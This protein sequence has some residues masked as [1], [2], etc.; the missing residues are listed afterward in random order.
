ME[1]PEVYA[2]LAEVGR[3]DDDKLEVQRWWDHNTSE[4]FRV[5][6]RTDPPAVV[7]EG[8]DW[9]GRWNVREYHPGR[10]TEYLAGVVLPELRAVRERERL[11]EQVSREQAEARRFSPVDDAALFAA[12]PVAEV[13]Q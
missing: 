4:H 2:L 7:Y 12:R 3:Y 10:W 1:Q 5:T 11:G 8:Y 6:L 13:R 9:G